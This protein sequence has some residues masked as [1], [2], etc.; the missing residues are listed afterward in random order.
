[1]PTLYDSLMFTLPQDKIQNR[2]RLLKYTDH[3]YNSIVHL[4]WNIQHWFRGYLVKTE[5]RKNSIYIMEGWSCVFPQLSPPLFP[6]SSIS[7]W[8]TDTF[9]YC[10]FISQLKSTYCIKVENSPLSIWTKIFFIHTL[11]QIT[12][13]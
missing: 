1:M 4:L 3:F 6:S 7:A 9:H 10:I 12:Y 13:Q 5:E 8:T 11:L 2:Y